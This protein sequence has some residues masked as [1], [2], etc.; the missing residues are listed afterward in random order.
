MIG[1]RRLKSWILLGACAWGAATA[2]LAQPAQRLVATYSTGHLYAQEQW[3]TPS[4]KWIHRVR[5]EH[6]RKRKGALKPMSLARQKAL[7]AKYGL[8]LVSA[9]ERAEI[10]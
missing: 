2:A 10:K 9:H 8:K 6:A 1:A 3:E 7:A 4:L 5:A